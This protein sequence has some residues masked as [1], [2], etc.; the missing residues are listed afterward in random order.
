MF[1]GPWWSRQKIVP[2]V[3]IQ[4][5]EEHLLAELTPRFIA[6]L[7]PSHGFSARFE[8]ARCMR[9]C[10][11]TT[12]QYK[13]GDILPNLS[14]SLSQQRNVKAGWSHLACGFHCKH[15][16]ELKLQKETDF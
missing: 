7:S 1:S 9:F 13:F 6:N 11:K 15:I 8:S 3:S 2:F 5:T 16:T 12:R 4:I 10:H 14:Q